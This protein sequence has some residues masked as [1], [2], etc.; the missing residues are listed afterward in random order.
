M[1]KQERDKAKPLNLANAVYRKTDI[2]HH[3]NQARQAQAEAN[4]KT[5]GDTVWDGR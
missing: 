3:V 4:A 2:R 1:A 5:F